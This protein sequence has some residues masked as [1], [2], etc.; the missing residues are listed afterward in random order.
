MLLLDSLLTRFC[1][2]FYGE[3]FDKKLSV[4]ER[5]SA[6]LLYLRFAPVNDRQNRIVNG[7]TKKAA[8]AAFYH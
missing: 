4:A 7:A 2:S 1:A 8:E 5:F 6:I 3:Y